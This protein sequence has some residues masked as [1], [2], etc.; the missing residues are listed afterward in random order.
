MS[1]SLGDRMKKYEDVWR[2]QLP[3]CMPVIIRLDG[4]CFHTL[5]RDMKRPIDTDF[6]TC[7]DVT[8]Q[9]LCKQVEGTQLAFIQSDEISLLLRNDM[10]FTTQ[11]WFDNNIQKMVSVSAAIAAITFSKALH[12]LAC[13]DSRAFVLPEEEITNY[14]L[15]R[16][17]DCSRNTI[18]MYGQSFYSH[19]ELH[20]VSSL[21][22][23]DKL[24]KEQPD[25]IKE[26]NSHMYGR[27]CIYNP[28]TKWTILP[29]VEKL[30]TT[31]DFI[32]KNSRNTITKEVVITHE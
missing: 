26:L 18:S 3:A 16:Q 15:W 17:L 10:T 13:F 14:F 12:K 20:C 24:I 6:M 23:L 5:T 31:P 21:D 19:K 32:K 29:L 11:G 25:C 30:N 27:L 7:M 1:N 22:L 8:T 2:F 4:R 28:E 9:E